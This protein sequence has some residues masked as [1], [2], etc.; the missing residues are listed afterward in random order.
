MRERIKFAFAAVAFL[1]FC[2]GCATVH[3][4]DSSGLDVKPLPDLVAEP[5]EWK[6]IAKVVQNGGDVVIMAP[7]GYSIPLKINIDIP[8]VNLV[9]GNNRIVFSRDVYIL[10][11]SKTLRISP[12]GKQWA[13]IKNMEAIQELFSFAKGKF[14]VGFGASEKEGTFMTVGIESN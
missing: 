5:D 3:Y 4:F 7:K 9:P 10:I 2:S 14:S 13:Y 11:S 12:D 1:I 8:I 6:Q